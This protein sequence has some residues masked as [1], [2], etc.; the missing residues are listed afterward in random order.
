MHMSDFK[1]NWQRCVARARENPPRDETV[2][3]GFASRVLSQ[4][5]ET[6]SSAASLE[7][8]WQRL[9]WRCLIATA[10]L[11]VICAVIEMPHFKPRPTMQPGIENT[12]AQLVW[13]L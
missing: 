10:A 13:S 5:S 7:M 8:A 3:F 2:P 12:V 1:T 11:L 4:R 6:A 9:I